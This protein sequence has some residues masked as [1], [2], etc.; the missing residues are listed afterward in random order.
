MKANDFLKAVE[1]CSSNHST[2]IVIN[3]PKNGF[4]G[5]LGTLNF[6]LHIT[7]CCASVV[8]KLIEAGYSLSMTEGVGLSVDKY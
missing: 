1:I 8:N 5:D 2:G 7:K 4:V 3:Q 6:T